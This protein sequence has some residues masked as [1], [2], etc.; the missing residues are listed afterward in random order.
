MGWI[1]SF[2]EVKDHPKTWRLAR[3]L[4]IPRREAI[5]ILHLLWWWT[6]DYA[7]D[8]DI[9]RF[10]PGDIAD[11]CLWE[12][13]D[14][15]T[16]VAALVSSGWIDDSEQG[17]HVHDWDQHSGKLVSKR[18]ADKLRM[19]AIRS[20]SVHATNIEQ[21]ATSIEQTENVAQMSQ[22]VAGRVEYSRLEKSSVDARVGQDDKNA[23]AFFHT[24]SEIKGFDQTL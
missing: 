6:M 16:F 15:A 21:L 4:S 19:R 22:P 11:A 5:G 2:Q 7:D 14:P 10:S 24:L 17:L 12:S 8:G 23:P 9:S 18:R 1:H 20:L 3:V 13:D